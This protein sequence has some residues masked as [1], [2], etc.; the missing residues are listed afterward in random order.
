MLAGA[1]C[2]SMPFDVPPYR[3]S[4]AVYG[5]LLN[6]RSVLAALGDAASRPP[7]DAA[8]A[9]PVL[10]I[11]P[12][13]TL[14]GSGSVVRIPAGIPELEVGACLG[15]VIGRAA[16]R[17]SEPRALDYVAGYLIV[18]DV[19]IPHTSYYR[20]S[21]RFKARDGYCPLGPAVTAR[22]AVAN[23]D[24]LTVRTYID[25][26]LAQTAS[27]ADLIRPAGRLLADVTEFMTLAPGDVLAL[28]AAGPAPRVRSG[29]TV[30]IEIDGLGSLVNRFADAAS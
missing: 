28:G 6:H 8:P 18:A 9:A 3:L 4:G 26:G 23:P 12:R 17:V 2:F 25:G 20:P 13:N 24:A 7:Y 11:K 10:Y 1:G 30:M 22:A 15:V 14:A 16:C 27:T 19:S 5:A 29:Q 21:V